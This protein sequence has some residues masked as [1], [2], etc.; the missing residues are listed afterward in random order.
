MNVNLSVFD[1]DQRP[2]T[3]VAAS[4]DAPENLFSKHSP[5]HAKRAPAIGFI[6]QRRENEIVLRYLAQIG[7][8]RQQPTDTILLVY[9]CLK[10]RVAG[11]SR[12]V[13]IPADFFL[14]SV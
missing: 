4:A 13:L 5:G 14:A 1:K 2:A 7:Y 8:A 3:T 12:S 11:Q 10:P 9:G 6:T